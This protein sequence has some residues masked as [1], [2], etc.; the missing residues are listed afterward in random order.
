[1]CSKFW[2]Y[3]RAEV[4]N[5][6]RLELCFSVTAHKLQVRRNDLELLHCFICPRTKIE[7]NV[8]KRV[9]GNS[10]QMLE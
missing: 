9:L 3:T 8:F 10:S 4:S 1:M 5:V 7:K 6:D 2:S